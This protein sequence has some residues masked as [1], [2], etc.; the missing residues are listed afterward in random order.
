MGIPIASGTVLATGQHMFCDEQL[1]KLLLSKEKVENMNLSHFSRTPTGDGEIFY[2][3]METNPDATIQNE[4]FVVIKYDQDHSFK[5]ALPPSLNVLGLPQGYRIIAEILQLNCTD[6]KIR[7]PRI[8]YFDS[9][10]NLLSQSY[11][12]NLPWVDA[13]PSSLIGLLYRKWCNTSAPVAE[14]GGH[15]AI[16]QVGGTYEGTNLAT[17]DKGGEGQQN[18]SFT[19]EQTGSE[20]SV[21]FHAASGGEG[22]GTG[23]LKGLMVE[24][25][26]LQ[27]TTPGCPGSY[28]TSFNFADDTVSWSYKGQDCSGSMTGH[29]TAKRTKFAT[30]R[31]PSEGRPK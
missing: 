19:V 22:K 17:Y 18:I 4:R 30:S 2:R 24:S 15:S 23:T 31:A 12:I 26:S 5:E 29:G 21:A 25:I 27:S 3:Q 9:Q 16:T 14:Q 8:E 28:E 11:P 6:N 20:V 10:N 13:V 7:L 1:R